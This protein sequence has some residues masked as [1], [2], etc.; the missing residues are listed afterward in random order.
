MSRYLRSGVRFITSIVGFE[1]KPR[2]VTPDTDLEF[3]R[4]EASPSAVDLIAGVEAQVLGHRRE[5]DTA[6]LL[7]QQ[8]A[9]IARRDGAVVG[10]AF[11]H[12]EELTGPIAA[13][14]PRDIPALL[15]LVENHAAEHEAPNVYFSVPMDNHTAVEHLLGRGYTLDPFVMQLLADAHWLQTDR[16]IHSGISY[17]L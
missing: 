5:I 6:L 14:D 13:L 8:P 7:E 3:E 10:F 11:G 1:S 9:W 2:P 4:L 17:I 15:D 12:R 16:W